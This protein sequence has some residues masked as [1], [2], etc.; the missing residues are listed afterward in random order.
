[1]QGPGLAYKD[2]GCKMFFSTMVNM[3]LWIMALGSAILAGVYFAFSVFVMKA[4]ARIDASHAIAAM[5]SFNSTI[6]RSLFMP[7]F[8]G[9]SLVSLLLVA[10][11][12]FNW[13]ALV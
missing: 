5:N 2:W 9:T 3:L 12:V 7:L 13:G 1:M 4:F 11:A 8:F 6:L 10:V